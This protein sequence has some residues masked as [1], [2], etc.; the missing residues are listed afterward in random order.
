MK[1]DVENYCSSSNSSFSTPLLFLPLSL[2][3]H[4]HRVSAVPTMPVLR[5]ALRPLGA[6]LRGRLHHG[7]PACRPVHRRAILPFSVP[8]FMLCPGA[9]DH[10]STVSA[11]IRVHQL[12]AHSGQ[13]DHRGALL[14]CRAGHDHAVGFNNCVVISQYHSYAENLNGL[15]NLQ[16]VEGYVSIMVR[17]TFQAA[18]TVATNPF[19]LLCNVQHNTLINMDGLSSLKSVGQ[20][21]NVKVRSSASQSRSG[22]RQ[23]RITCMCVRVCVVQYNTNLTSLNGLRSLSSVGGLVAVEVRCSPSPAG[24]NC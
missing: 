4:T 5:P 23:W 15:L 18:Q 14:P 6:G 13:H 20:Y 24:S 11:D 7:Q 22:P 8:C 21:V 2:P 3:L 1:P 16:S 9:H 19:V 10:Y 12:E 17:P